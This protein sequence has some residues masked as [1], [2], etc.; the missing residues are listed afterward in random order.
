[1]IKKFS[2]G[3]ASVESLVKIFEPSIINLL[4]AKM[5]LLETLDY[6]SVSFPRKFSASRST[7]QSDYEP[8]K[9]NMRFEDK[10]S[11]RRPE[12]LIGKPMKN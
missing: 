1:M 3:F 10:E 4:C 9:S 5:S 12:K 11:T 2:H 7:S 6:L 8:L